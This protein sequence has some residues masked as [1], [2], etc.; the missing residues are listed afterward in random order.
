MREQVASYIDG[1]LLTA[2][3]FGGDRDFD[4]REAIDITIKNTWNFAPPVFMTVQ[5]FAP[6]VLIN[7]LTV[8]ITKYESHRGQIEIKVEPIEDE[9]T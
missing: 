3:R 2:V 9:S 6:V 1:N 4:K 5:E 7:L 8:G